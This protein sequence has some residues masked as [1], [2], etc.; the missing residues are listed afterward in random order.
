MRQRYWDSTWNPLY[1]GE[2][3]LRLGF[4][5]PDIKLIPV[6][7]PNSFNKSVVAPYVK[8]TYQE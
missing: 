3:G 6:F 5:T 8:Y 1:K 7:L 2:Y 4:V